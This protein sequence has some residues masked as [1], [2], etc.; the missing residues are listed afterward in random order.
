M[1]EVDHAIEACH[2]AIEIYPAHWTLV[3]VW[4]MLGEIHQ[5]RG[6]LK[7]AFKAFLTASEFRGTD[8]RAG[9]SVVSHNY[10]TTR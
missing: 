6:D 1:G 2:A 4:S 10:T 9:H 3:H 7:A 5:E 8:E